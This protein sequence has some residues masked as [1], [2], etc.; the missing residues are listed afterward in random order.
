MS[1]DFPWGFRRLG[2]AVGQRP[3]F[4]YD[5]VTIVFFR[6]G[7]GGGSVRIISVHTMWRDS[8]KQASKQAGSKQKDEARL[9]DMGFC[10]VGFNLRLTTLAVPA[11]PV[12]ERG[13]DK[14]H[15]GPPLMA[16]ARVVDAQVV[17]RGSDLMSGCNGETMVCVCVID[18]IYYWK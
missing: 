16:V 17:R 14:L 8:F 12:R 6:G 7:G 9:G 11:E 10:C 3:V 4:A 18:H 5:P 1:P 2:V 13:L 15:G